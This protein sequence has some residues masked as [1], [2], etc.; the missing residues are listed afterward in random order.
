MFMI[1]DVVGVDENIIE[2][3]NNAYIEEVTKQVVHEGLERCWG[4]REVKRHDVELEMS[5]P[6]SRSG[7][8]TIVG[9]YHDLVIAAGEVDF[10]E[11]HCL[12]KSIKNFVDSG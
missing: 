4:I 9:G 8:V 3:N 5:I 6:G 2:V 10:G 1:L 12:V 11:N 7:F